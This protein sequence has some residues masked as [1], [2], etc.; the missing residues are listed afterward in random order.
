M[1]RAELGYAYLAYHAFRPH[2]ATDRHMHLHNFTGA[3][4]L[5]VAAES[6]W[7][8]FQYAEETARLFLRLP[9]LRRPFR[10][11]HDPWYYGKW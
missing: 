2:R 7:Q 6:C 3:L 8:D 10:V 9:V 5:L 1:R 4:D 11:G